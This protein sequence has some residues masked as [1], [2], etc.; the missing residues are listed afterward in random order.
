MASIS[1]RAADVA[2][3]AGRKAEAAAHYADAYEGL[4][5][6][7][8]DRAAL[9]ELSADQV[10]YWLGRSAHDRARIGMETKDSAAGVWFD[11]AVEAYDSVGERAVHSTWRERALADKAALEYGRGDFSAAAR[12]YG[13]LLDMPGLS[14]EQELA[15]RI[16]LDVGLDEK[17][18][19]ASVELRRGSPASALEV[20]APVLAR[21]EL[22]AGRERARYLSARALFD[23]GRT[24]EAAKAYRSFLADYPASEDRPGALFALGT[25]VGKLGD[26][27][28]A[29]ILYK[30][31]LS[32]FPRYADADRVR[33]A[34][35]D[36]L[37][38]SS[39]DVDGAGRL[40][41]TV[42]EKGEDA[43]LRARAGLELAGT[44]V[45]SDDR[46]A[47]LRVIEE[48]E[49]L[50]SGPV[51]HEIA[52]RRGTILASLGRHA[53]AVGA[54]ADAAR[55]VDKEL[56]VRAHHEQARSLFALGRSAEA[57]SP[58]DV[59]RRSAR[60]FTW[61]AYNAP[62]EERRESAIFEAAAA[63]AELASVEEAAGNAVAAQKELV[64]AK[65][66]LALSKNETGA[67]TRTREID[68]RLRSLGQA[69][70]VR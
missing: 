37:V 65:R 56:R 29:A 1:R 13:E 60:A 44:L 53:D 41:R 55:S 36:A 52:E 35:G 54:F 22:A 5:E 40:Y 16:G 31:A 59:L 42:F 27:G 3:R 67:A 45:A 12:T 28:E 70:P 9:E 17:P 14:T 15:A 6:T 48:A 43:E 64:E 34:L 47:A 32:D 7:R 69:R 61:V 50:S 10:C 51:V 26:F 4:V 58:A 18:G 66:L 68:A 33:L 19:L 46:P 2:E 21:A 24:E 25:C 57:E 63:L 23:Q 8:S 49:T 38:R 20:L 39:G 30:S 62:G 11:R